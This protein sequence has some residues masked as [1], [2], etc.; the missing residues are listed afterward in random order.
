MISTKQPM[1][2]DPMLDQPSKQGFFRRSPAR[3]LLAAIVLAGV[4]SATPAQAADA[5]ALVKEGKKLLDAKKFDEA[6]PKFAEA[7]QA[8]SN[9]ATL[10]DLALCH[11]K[12]GKIATAWSELLDAEADARKAGRSDIETR[13]RANGRALEPK[14]PRIAITITSP[15]PGI[16]VTI[17]GQKIDTAAQGKGRPVDPGEHKIIATAP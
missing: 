15:A 8:S 17:D 3:L 12:Q 1:H 4:A 5:D 16:E 10:V 7:Y 14:L 6:C 13:A 11:E 2:S 9:V